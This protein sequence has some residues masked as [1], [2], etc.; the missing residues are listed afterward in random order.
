MTCDL[1]RDWPAGYMEH[2]VRFLADDALRP[3]GANV[4][5][6]VLESPLLFPLQRRSE[7]IQMIRLARSLDRPPETVMEI[8]ADKGGGI[9]HWVKCLPSVRRMI[10]NEIRGCPYA[11]QMSAAFPSVSFLFSERRSLGAKTHIDVLRFLKGGTLDVLFI[12]GDKNLTEMDFAR[13]A[14]LVRVGGLI[15]IHDVASHHPADAF[16]R[17]RTME[18]IRTEMIIDTSDSR[19]AIRREWAGIPPHCP[20]EAW[21]RHWGGRSCGVGVIHVDQR[22]KEGQVEELLK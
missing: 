17:I 13:Y 8:G 7:L 11:V 9:Y 4:Y 6:D 19:E 15:F 22:I 20:Y 16:H 10:A 3:A 14:P 5:D 2:L 1:E 12:D 21:L 18:G